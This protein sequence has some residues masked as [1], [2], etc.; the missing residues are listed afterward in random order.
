MTV[1]YATDYFCQVSQSAF[2]QFWSVWKNMHPM[3]I[4]AIAKWGDV[5]HKVLNYDCPEHMCIYNL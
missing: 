4:K 1:K 2:M 5:D 3:A